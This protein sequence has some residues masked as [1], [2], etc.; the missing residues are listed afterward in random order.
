MTMYKN[1]EIESQGAK[2]AG[3]EW[4]VPFPKAA[5]YLIHGIGEH[6]GRYDHVAKA[7]ND[8]GIALI[9]MDLRGHGRSPGKR[10]HIEKREIIRKDIDNLI[11]YTKNKYPD[12]PLVHYGH[13]LGGNITLDYRLRGELSS[14]PAGYLITSPWVQLVRPITGATYYFVKVAAKILPKAAIAQSIENEMLGN[15]DL[16]EN[17]EDIDL[18]HQKIS[19]TTAIEGF[20]IAKDLMNN[21]VADLYG[22]GARPVLLMHGANDPICDVRGS[23]A[24]ANNYGEICKYLEWEDYLHELHNGTNEKPYEPVVDKMVSWIL[25]TVEE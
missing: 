24:I 17:E 2:L 3:Y 7:F 20:V 14:E 18:R 19:L 16:I 8:A 9:S 10:G 15:V 5:V 6:A 4:H 1:F 12:T 13:S 23:R 11:L 22:G 21:N 25:E